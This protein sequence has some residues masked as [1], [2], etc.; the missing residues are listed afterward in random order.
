MTKRVRVYYS[1]RVQGVGFR[2]T[3]REVAIGFEVTGFVQNLPDGR[4]E[5]VAEGE[6]RELEDFLKGIEASHLAPLIRGKQV[7]WAEPTGEFR[8]FRIAY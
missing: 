8:S 6:A 2:Y 7:D 1:G 4:V 5:L 3:A